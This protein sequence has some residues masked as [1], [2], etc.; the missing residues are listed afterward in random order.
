MK[1]LV[2]TGGFVFIDL[3]LKPQ[4]KLKY[5]PENEHEAQ[6]DCNRLRNPLRI[7]DLEWNYPI[8]LK[9]LPN[10][11]DIENNAPPLKN[12]MMLSKRTP[13]T[14]YNSSSANLAL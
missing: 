5:Y 9:F 12:Y 7:A 6:S 13:E 11:T 2:P 10:N 14:R 1:P 3:T 4:K 8:A